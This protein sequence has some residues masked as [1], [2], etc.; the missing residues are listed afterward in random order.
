MDLENRYPKLMRN[1]DVARNLPSYYGFPAPIS[2]AGI[3]TTAAT[4][5]PTWCLSHLTHSTCGISCQLFINSLLRSR[6]KKER[7][8]RKTGGR[9]IEEKTI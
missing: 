1:N 6:E 3:Q 2:P 9:F 5:I 4:A 8:E 7:E